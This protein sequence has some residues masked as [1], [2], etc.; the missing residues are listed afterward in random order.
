MSTLP[1]PS[2]SVGLICTCRSA[3]AGTFDEY[4][5]WFELNVLP[6]NPTAIPPQR[7]TVHH[8]SGRKRTIST[9]DGKPWLTDTYLEYLASD[10]WDLIRTAAL[11]RA[12]HKCRCGA[13]NDL[14][15]HHITYKRL[16]HELPDDLRV[17]CSPC[18]DKE[19]TRLDRKRRWD[20]RVEAVASK[21][22]GP[23]YDLDEYEYERIGEWLERQ[24][25]RGA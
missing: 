4:L 2:A 3:D 20:R 22:Y 18:H 12:G 24:D 11:T 15:V 19:H 6:V 7:C 23:D 8:P 9:G 10:E 13:T 1:A 16:G 21:W 17:L 14:H 25:E 5:E